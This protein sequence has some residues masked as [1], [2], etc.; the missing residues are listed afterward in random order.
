MGAWASAGGSA[1]CGVQGAVE[2]G[3]SNDREERPWGTKDSGV[4]M[5]SAKDVAAEP[6]DLNDH[7]HML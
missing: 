6:V 4:S 5:K 3:S 2:C 7:E 1:L